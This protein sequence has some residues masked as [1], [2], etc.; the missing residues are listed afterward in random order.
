MLDE[1]PQ[2]ERVTFELNRYE[3]RLIR[4]RLTDRVHSLSLSFEVDIR[5]LTNG[6]YAIDCVET[7]GDRNWWCRW[8]NNDDI[9]GIR[10]NFFTPPDG[11]VLQFLSEF[12]DEPI[13]IVL[14]A[15]VALEQYLC[16]YDSVD[17]FHQ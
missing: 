5:W 8:E 4:A 12:P 1:I 10:A 13:D 11:E 16:E 7:S 17:R 6:D 14:T 15:V 3:P 9:P 2:I